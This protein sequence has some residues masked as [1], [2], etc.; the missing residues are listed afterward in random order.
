MP[1]IP[2]PSIKLKGGSGSFLAH[3]ALTNFYAHF[4]PLPCSVVL[5]GSFTHWYQIHTHSAGLSPI[6]FEYYYGK[7]AERFDYNLRHL[8]RAVREKAPLMGAHAGMADLFVPLM[9]KGRAVA[10]LV[11]GPFFTEAP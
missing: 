8:A 7:R 10:V 5:P 9:R 4:L 2:D 11:S 6:Q 1:K 3:H